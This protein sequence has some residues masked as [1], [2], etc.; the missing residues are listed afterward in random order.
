MKIY[1]IL[2][3]TFILTIILCS[4]CTSNRWAQIDN[5]LDKGYCWDYIRNRCEKSDLGFCVKNKKECNDKDG[6]WI[7]DKLYCKFNH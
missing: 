2:F 7:E 6:Y 3:F 5:C 4:G 1:I